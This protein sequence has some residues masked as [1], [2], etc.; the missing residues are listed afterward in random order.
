MGNKWTSRWGGVE[1]LSDVNSVQP[2]LLYDRRSSN[3]TL[4]E[5]L[6][7]SRKSADKGS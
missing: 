7:D 2:I 5:V 6:V 3:S 4:A 1:L